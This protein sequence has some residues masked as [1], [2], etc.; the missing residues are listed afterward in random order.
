MGT[1][2]DFETASPMGL[3]MNF[4]LFVKKFENQSTTG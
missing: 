2:F 1:E 4:G 3:R